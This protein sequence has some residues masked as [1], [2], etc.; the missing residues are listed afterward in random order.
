MS[1]LKKPSDMFPECQHR[2]HLWCLVPIVLTRTPSFFPGNDG[3]RQDPDD[4]SPYETVYQARANSYFDG[5]KALW[6]SNREYLAKEIGRVGSQKDSDCR[7]GDAETDRS[8][9]HRR[10][11]LQNVQL[12][13]TPAS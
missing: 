4:Q 9:D 12:S 5:I 13:D 1:E 10:Q 6:V 8:S 11:R 3:H 2:L 7:S